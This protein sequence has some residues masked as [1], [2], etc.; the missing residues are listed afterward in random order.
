ML[1][2]NGFSFG[3]PSSRF[4]EEEEEEEEAQQEIRGL[5]LSDFLSEDE[6]DEDRIELLAFA[7]VVSRRNADE[8]VEN[9]TVPPIISL[10][11]SRFLS[12]PAFRLDWINVSGF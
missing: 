5:K 6:E 7:S 9:A 10:S 1:L 3:I 12:L 11:L 4:L 8:A 2:L